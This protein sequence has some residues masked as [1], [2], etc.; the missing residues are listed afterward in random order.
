LQPL[1]QSSENPV[2]KFAFKFNLDRYSAATLA[3]ASHRAVLKYRKQ[4]A[5]C[6][7]VFFASCWNKNA[8]AC[9][10]TKF[11]LSYFVQ[12]QSAARASG[13]RD[14]VVVFW[15]HSIKRLFFIRSTKRTASRGA[16]ESRSWTRTTGT[17]GAWGASSTRATRTRRIATRAGTART[18]DARRRLCRRRRRMPRSRCRTRGGCRS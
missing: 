1:H 8:R 3:V 15:F 13:L 17:G 14:G 7:I 11:S 18:C 6:M 10:T 16:G 2:S 12:G 5:F 4:I 9:T